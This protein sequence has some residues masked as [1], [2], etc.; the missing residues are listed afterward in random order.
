MEADRNS[1]LWL[2]S[3]KKQDGAAYTGVC[4]GE[5]VVFIP[6]SFLLDVWKEVTSLEKSPGNRS[7]VPHKCQG[8]DEH[9]SPEGSAGERVAPL[10]S[11]ADTA[12][13]DERWRLT[14][15]RQLSKDVSARD[16]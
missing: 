10:G 11:K 3:E 6:E 7:T 15:L 9:S 16:V 5:E 12:H 4:V 2:Q 14:F 13:Q 8:L 1:E